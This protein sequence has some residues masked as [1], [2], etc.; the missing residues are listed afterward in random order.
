M[1]IPSFSRIG[2]P[3][4]PA[5]SLSP[6]HPPAPRARDPCRKT[7]LNKLDVVISLKLNQ[8][9]CMD[10]AVEAKATEGGEEGEKPR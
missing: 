4:H 6:H 2:S 7:E 3:A 9:Y 5:F 8:L 1:S 10:N